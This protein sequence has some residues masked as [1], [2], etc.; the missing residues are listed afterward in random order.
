M[1]NEI[2]KM[3]NLIAYVI[4][5]FFNLFFSQQINSQILQGEWRDHLSYSFCYRIAD[6]GNTIFCATQSGMLSY[7]KETNEVQKHSKVT[8]L[9]DVEVSTIAYSNAANKLIIG[10][11]NGNIDIIAL[12]DDSVKNLADIKRKSLTGNK[13]INSIYIVD[14]L[15]YLSC[16]FGIVVLDIMKEEIKDSYLFGEG[17]NT[18]LVYDVTIID[19]ILYAATESGIYSVDLNSP[20]LV[21]YNYWSQLDYVPQFTSSYSII[22][23][24]ENTLYAVYHEPISDEDMIITIENNSYQEWNGQYDTVVNDLTSSNGYFSISGNNRGLIYFPNGSIFLDFTSYGTNHILVDSELNVFVASTV[25]G[26][27]NR[28]NNNDLKYLLVNGPRYREVNKVEARGD[29]IWVSSGGPGNNMYKHGAAYSFIE[30]KW[31]SYTASDIPTTKILGNTYKFAIDPQDYNH[32][33]AAAFFYGL[34]EFRDGE[35]ID[36]IEKDDLEIF[37]DI[38]DIVDLRPVGLQYDK[39]GNLYVLLNLASNPLVIYDNEGNWRR[40]QI[41]NPILDREDIGYSDLLVTSTGQIWICSERNGIVVLEEDGAGNFYSNSFVIKNRDGNTISKAYCLDEDNEG[42]IWVGT[43]SGPIIYHS[44]TYIIN[45]SNVEGHQ[46]KIPRNDGTPNADYL[47]FSELILDIETDGAN[48]HWFATANS[49]AFLLSENGMNTVHNFRDD[50]S[51]MLSNSVSG[52]GINEKDG[53]VFFATSLGLLSYRGDAI[54]GYSEYTDVYVY[55]NPVRPDYDGI[56][57]ITGLVENSIVKIT[58]ISGTLV[59]ETI[60]LG[61]Q[62]I[63]DGENFDGRRVASGIYLVLLA[64]ED[65]SKSH[66]TKLLFLH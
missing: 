19:N 53:E 51:P 44:P 31:N 6:A 15:A 28:L 61:G 2:S 50:N 17:G 21:D 25:S 34:I 46:I 37:S 42:D 54:K 36:I 45:E 10:Y 60:S 38:D 59:Y 58:D 35:V 47:L 32:V 30:N 20:N 40:L 56:I 48:R 57:T 26:F 4:F 24:H 12:N 11:L 16:S 62:A 8:G 13:S 1:T 5:S 33:F 18:I 7:N 41:S 27:T 49:G 64:N 14:E 22:E 3:K 65:G 66:M 23:N 55:P 9:S 39:Q 29:H 63:W 43:N 52:I